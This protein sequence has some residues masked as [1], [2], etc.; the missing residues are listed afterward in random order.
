MWTSFIN[1]TNLKWFNNNNKIYY[2]ELIKIYNNDIFFLPQTGLNQIN[3]IKWC[4]GK[5]H[6]VVIM[7]KH[8][9]YVWKKI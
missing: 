2:D 6:H 7:I 9:S 4:M 8:G 5:I 1:K 3:Q